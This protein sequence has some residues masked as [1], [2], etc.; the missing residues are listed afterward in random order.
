[1]GDKEAGECRWTTVEVIEVVE[2]REGSSGVEDE[3]F[4]VREV[5]AAIELVELLAGS[6]SRK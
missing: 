5:W 3:F 4:L 2:V 6:K 1:M